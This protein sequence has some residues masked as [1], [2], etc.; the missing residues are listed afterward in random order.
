M[1]KTIMIMI[2]MHQQ[3]CTGA[4]ARTQQIKI[5]TLLE[6]IIVIIIIVYGGVVHTS[7]T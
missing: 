5:K 2:V 4:Y 7:T 6:P 1:A 3:Y